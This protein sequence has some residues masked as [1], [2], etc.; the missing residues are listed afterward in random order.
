MAGPLRQPENRANLPAIGFFSTRT[1]RRPNP[2]GISCPRLLRR[3]GNRLTVTGIDAWDGTPILDLKG[4]FP[5]D[6]NRPDATIPDWLEMLWAH[7][8]EERGR[9]R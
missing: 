2:I 5:R 7:H 3:E 9:P 8:D 1:P 4:Y 6:E